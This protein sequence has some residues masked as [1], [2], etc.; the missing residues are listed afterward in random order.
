MGE[1]V[2]Y[3]Y[4]LMGKN[5]DDLLQPETVDPTRTV[6]VAFASF[7]FGLGEVVVHKSKQSLK[8]VVH[9]RSIHQT[10]AGFERFYT[11]TIITPD[12]DGS[13][14]VHEQNARFYEYEIERDDGSWHDS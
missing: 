5:M 7:K 13:G 8:W 1:Q 6:A 4:N 10:A 14:P 3:R 12:M 9:G 11:C 2:S